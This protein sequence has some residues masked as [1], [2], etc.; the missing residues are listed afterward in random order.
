MKINPIRE[1]SFIILL[2]SPVISLLLQLIFK[3]VRW[4][5]YWQVF[6]ILHILLFV[7]SVPLHFFTFQHFI[8]TGGNYEGSRLLASTIVLIV[9]T[10][11]I[12]LFDNRKSI[13]K[14]R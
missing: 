14:T 8:A 9:I 5:I 13:F 11:A 4:A 12:H 10:I 7:V 3:P 2:I 6:C 1:I